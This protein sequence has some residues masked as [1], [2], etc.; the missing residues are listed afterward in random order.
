MEYQDLKTKLTEAKQQQISPVADLI[1]SFNPG[2]FIFFR[3]FIYLI[4]SCIWKDWF[5]YCLVLK[6]LQ[7]RM[8]TLKNKMTLIYSYTTMV[9]L[10]PF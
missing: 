9:N 5:S 6:I 4:N 1:A 3:F 10:I 8:L 2:L 7:N